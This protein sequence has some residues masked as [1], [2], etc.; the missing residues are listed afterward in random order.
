MQLVVVCL[1]LKLVDSLLPVCREDVSVSALKALV[2]L[3][4]T[5]ELRDRIDKTVYL[6][7][8]RLLCRILRLAQTLAQKASLS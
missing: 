3:R 2:Y 8:P 5:I 1:G 7:L 6:H 4:Q